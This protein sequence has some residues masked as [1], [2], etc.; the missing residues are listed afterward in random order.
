[1]PSVIMQDVYGRGIWHI[2]IPSQIY[3]NLQVTEK[4]TW[5]Y[6]CY[7]HDAICQE[8]GQ[9]LCD[10]ARLPPPIYTDEEERIVVW[11]MQEAAP[12]EIA[13]LL[14]ALKICEDD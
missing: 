11:A 4:Q 5:M 13:C 3:D 2:H 14:D 12:C 1:M 7:E 6:D 9:W 8:T 10:V